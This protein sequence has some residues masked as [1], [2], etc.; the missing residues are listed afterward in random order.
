MMT[1]DE[2]WAEV[3]RNMDEAQAGINEGIDWAQDEFNR[4]IEAIPWYEWTAKPWLHW[5]VNRGI[6]ALQEAAN[7]LWDLFEEKAPEIWEQAN[8]VQGDP[9]TLGLIQNSYIAASAVLHDLKQGDLPD[10]IGDVRD[11][12]GGD[13]RGADAFADQAEKQVAAIS[14]VEDGL[15]TAIE[16]CGQGS[17]N[18]LS[19]WQ[20]IIDALIDFASQTVSVVKDGCDAGQILTLEIGPTEELIG[21]AVTTVLK[22]ANQLGRYLAEDGTA[23]AAVWKI[24]ENGIDGLNSGNAWPKIS[25]TDGATM[26][27]SGTW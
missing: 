18:I 14:A 25:G 22:L 24:A 27:N 7:S 17:S 13:S 3:Q 11:A 1:Y 5:T 15:K 21:S 20:D 6:D 23:N 9:V 10:A 8:Q 16:M 12:W 19:S 2:F 26:E 4:R